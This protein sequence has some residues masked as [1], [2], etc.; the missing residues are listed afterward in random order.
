M[1]LSRT[2]IRKIIREE[3]KQIR[4]VQHPVLRKSK[5]T[6]YLKESNGALKPVSFNS[7]L[8]QQ[9]KGVFSEQQVRDILES[10]FNHDMR[11]FNCYST[12]YTNLSQHMISE[13]LITE[14]GKVTKKGRILE[15][16]ERGTVLA[17]S[18]MRKYAASLILEQEEEEI[19]VEAIKTTGQKAAGAIGKGLKAI[20]GVLA[21]PFKAW[22][23][24]KDKVWEAIKGALSKVG[25]AIAAFG[26]KYN[27]GL[28]QQVTE[29]IKAAFGAVAKFCGKNKWTKILCGVV[30]S[31]CISLLVK[32]AIATVVAQCGLSM[33]SMVM[34]WA[35][36]CAAGAAGLTENNS[37]EE[38]VLQEAV[39]EICKAAAEAGSHATN[40]MLNSIKGA[41]KLMA[42]KGEIADAAQLDS[43]LNFVDKYEEVLEARITAS[44]SGAEVLGQATGGA[45][46]SPGTTKILE[47]FMDVADSCT[48]QGS[49][50]AQSAL[51][52]AIKMTDYNFEESASEITKNLIALGEEGANVKESQTYIALA[53]IVRA[54]GM[55]AEEAQK[56]AETLGGQLGYDTSPAWSKAAKAAKEAAKA[57]G[58]GGMDFASGLKAK[59]EAGQASAEEIA[60]YKEMTD[61]EAA[62]RARQAIKENLN[63]MRQLAGVL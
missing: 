27:I 57:A 14:G 17:E 29:W 1:S 11:M 55:K 22:K 24:F 56:L 28:I 41:L 10:S 44:T 40:G 49:K 33:S 60:K 9:K 18:D 50:L 63:R 25:Q 47:D 21:T 19:D 13:G 20:G 6:V 12:A 5:C 15:K 39:S 35:G 58:E 43:A 4:K 61:L 36:G 37:D 42:A 3:L 32:A 59:I 26:D 46:A 23:W 38:P 2:Q 48:S 16:K 30:A 34:T 53:K 54:G 8:K 31:V 45:W 62:N 7:V 51:G 52:K